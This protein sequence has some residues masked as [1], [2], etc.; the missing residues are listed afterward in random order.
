MIDAQRRASRHAGGGLGRFAGPGSQVVAA[1]DAEVTSFA[2]WV[3]SDLRRFPP[4]A[5]FPSLPLAALAALA[6]YMVRM[7][8]SH[9]ALRVSDSPLHTDGEAP[10]PR[11]LTG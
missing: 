11:L 7:A 10:A 4:L 9:P 5:A 1:V 6:I 2:G 8:Q 3:P